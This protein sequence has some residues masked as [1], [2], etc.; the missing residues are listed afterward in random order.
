MRAWGVR[1]AVSV[2]VGVMLGV[3]AFGVSRGIS[4][5][6]LLWSEQAALRDMSGVVLGGLDGPPATDVRALR[7]S[8]AQQ[9][10]AAH[11]LGVRI[12]YGVAAV[13]TLA[14]F[15][16]LERRA[17]ADVGTIPRPPS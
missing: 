8:L 2:L 16:W 9:A 4:G 5:A 17:W 7:R 14:C 6:W 11:E 3:L 10:S 13:G 12:G 15:L 1:I